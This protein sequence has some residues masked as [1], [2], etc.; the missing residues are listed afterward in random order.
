MGGEG[1]RLSYGP[2][3][4]EG[5]VDIDVVSRDD[6][7]RHPSLNGEGNAG[8]DSQCRRWIENIRHSPIVQSGVRGVSGS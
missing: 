8:I 1:D 4:Q 7:G 2:L 6:P 3:H 5:A